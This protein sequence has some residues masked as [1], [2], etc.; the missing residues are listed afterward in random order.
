MQVVEDLINLHKE[1]TLTERVA[2]LEDELERIDSL[3]CYRT[4]LS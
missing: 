1:E 4:E 3:I 2:R